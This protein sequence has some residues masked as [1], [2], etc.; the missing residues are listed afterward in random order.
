MIIH[1]T[2][3]TEK[4]NSLRRR[5]P[6]MQSIATP[7]GKFASLSEIPSNN[8][9]D[10]LSLVNQLPVINRLNFFADRCVP[11]MIGLPDNCG[12]PIYWQP[13]ASFKPGV[14]AKYTIVSG[15]GAISV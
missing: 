2:F 15:G 11:A 1:S 7:W 9:I 13:G 4:Y 14:W 8:K 12:E 3:S 6:Y 5:R 10:H